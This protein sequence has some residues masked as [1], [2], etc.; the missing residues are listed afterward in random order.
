LMYVK[1]PTN[2]LQNQSAWYPIWSACTKIV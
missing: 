1:F 2:V